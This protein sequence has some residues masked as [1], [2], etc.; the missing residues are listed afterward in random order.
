MTPK[1]NEIPIVGIGVTAGSLNELE[2]FL[3][4]TPKKTGIVFA[5]VQYLPV[6]VKSNISDFIKQISTVPIKLIKDG[7]AY[8]ANKL[9][10][11]PDGFFLNINNGKFYLVQVEDDEKND[12]INRFFVSL[13]DYKKAKTTAIL[14]SSAGEDGIS[15]TK[16]MAEHGGLFFS[17]AL[18]EPGKKLNFE[19]IF[20]KNG[21]TD[22]KI[23]CKDILEEI[24]KTNLERGF[25][26][27]NQNGDK[28]KLELYLN[29]IFIHLL[30][31]TGHDFSK[32]KRGTIK[33]RIERRLVAL[34]IDKLS[35]YVELLVLDKNEALNLKKEL[36]ISVT[37]FFRDPQ[38]FEDL[39]DKIIPEMIAS[40]K[41]GLIRIWIPACATGEE[42]YT[43]TMIMQ[44]YIDENDLELQ[45][46]VF[47]SDID[48]AAIEK[49]REGIYSQEIAD[50]IPGKYLDKYFTRKNNRYRVDKQIREK[51]IFAEQNVLQDPPYS[52]MDLI[53]C[54]NLLIY[55][56]NELQEQALATFHYALKSK[57]YLLLGNSESLGKSTSL[58]ADVN[59]KMKLFQKVDNVINSTRYW[60]FTSSKIYDKS[61]NMKQNFS[62]Q[63][64]LPDLA[65]EVV[66][67]RF[68]PPVIIINH[69]LDI[70]YLHGRTSVYLEL[71][72]GVASLNIL[73]SVL[74][75]LKAPLGTTI[76]RARNTGEEIIKR[77]VKIDTERISSIIDI[78][79]SPVKY[80][81]KDTDMLMVTF[82]ESSIVSDQA[83]V[84]PTESEQIA[85][86]EKELKETQDYLQST[87]EELETTNEELKAAN[88]EE[89]STNEELQSANEELE[90]S[91]E[92]LQAVNEELISANQELQNK[93]DELSKAN[94]DIS[95][96]FSSTQIATVFL[97]KELR[98]T[99]FTNSIVNI[100]D[101]MPTD[102]G[103]PIDQFTNKLEYD[104]F[105]EDIWEVIHSLK[106][107][108]MEV[109]TSDNSYFWM[110]VNP[111]RTVEGA[112]EGVCVTFT[113][114]SEKKK[115]EEELVRYKNHLEDLVEER[116]SELTESMRELDSEKLK[117]Q[118][119]LD[120]AAV[121]FISLDLHGNLTLANIHASEVLGY[122]QQ[123]LVGMNWFEHFLPDEVKTEIHDIFDEM[124]NSSSQ[125]T[126]PH[127]NE[128]IIKDG[129][130]RT[131]AWNNVLIKDEAGDI[132]GFLSSGEDIT[133]RKEA[134]ESLQESE[135][136]LRL[137]QDAG[138][139]GM[140]VLDFG[141]KS[142]SASEIFFKIHGLDVTNSV[143]LEDFIKVL[144]ESEIENVSKA[145]ND[146]FKK[147]EPYEIEHQVTDQKTREKKWVRASGELVCDEAGNRLKLIGTSQDITKRKEAE[148][149]LIRSREMYK[150]LFNNTGA[151]TC[152][153]GND[154]ILTK[155]NQMFVE[156]SGFSA[157]DIV[158][159]KIWSDF[160]ADED[161]ERIRGYHQR[162]SL[163]DPDVPNEYEFRF[164]DSK[165]D[166][167][168]I[169][170]KISV[171][172]ETGIRIASLLNI[173]ARVKAEKAIMASE[174][175][176]KSIFEYS[177][178]GIVIGS[179]DGDL[180]D[181]NDEFIQML[182]YSKEELLKKNYSEFTHPEDLESEVKFFDELI[183]GK[184]ENYRIEKR[185]INSSNEIVWVDFSIA[186][187]RNEKGEI[188]FLIGMVKDMT[189]R[190]MFQQELI[191]QN[192]FIQ[193]ILDNLP[194]G[195]ATNS[196]N[197]GAAGYMNA[198]FEEIYG[199]A[200]TEIPSIN[201]FFEKVYPDEEYKKQIKERVM[202]DIQSGDPSRMHWEDIQITRSDGAQRTINAINIPL[203]DQNMMVSTV[204]DVTDLKETQE[205][206]INAKEEAE[207]ANNL[208]SAFLANTSHE[209]RTPL[210]G[211]IGFTD[212]LEEEM[213]PTPK[214][215][216]YL[217]V[218]KNS[219]QQLLAIIGDI[220]DI[221]KIDT[222]QMS[223]QEEIVNL[224]DLMK[225]VYNFHI[226]SNLYK[227]KKDVELQLKR[228]NQNAIVNADLARLRQILDNLVTNALK[229]TS[230][231]YVKFGYSIEKSGIEI[232]VND[233]GLGIPEG[234]EENIFG[235]F[236]KLGSKAGTG[237]G[238]SI[239]KGLVELM[240]GEISLTSK[241]EK[242]TNFKINLPFAIQE[243][244]LVDE[245]T[246][247]KEEENELNLSGK[248]ILVAEDDFSSYFLIEQ[249]LN[250]TKARIVHA[251][252]GQEV[253]DLMEKEKAELILMDINMPVMDGLEATRLVREADNK[254]PIVAQTAYAMENEK[255]KCF[256]AGCDDYI[257]KPLTKSILLEKL[258]KL[259]L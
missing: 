8:K 183:K 103:R 185:Y 110:R 14:F 209:I 157:T 34:K 42:A 244:S 69:N 45:L 187:R 79:V 73:N 150:D 213:D 15:G 5:L 36:L 99:R 155:C 131:V 230:K 112:V 200:S 143:S 1:K 83:D 120:I 204:V 259:M 164:I 254:I 153:F 27:E 251:Q 9:Y 100:I 46:Q 177:N 119:Y 23:A 191:V 12:P 166:K 184:R 81:G 28:D 234:Q 233:T 44:N 22:H 173:S 129:S 180:L 145:F 102:L 190:V 118:Q 89:Q 255:L 39:S 172:K 152:T 58:F 146:T 203:E 101:L 88:E 109:K 106:I 48:V 87:I 126:I 107:K 198:K 54:R 221:S 169:F 181:A 215:E 57:G 133:E 25:D 113:E 50:S 175:K 18:K 4:N 225:E 231:G 206:L 139:I 82:K 249:F 78:I 105:V 158:G 127:E 30:K 202:N 168:H 171:N 208:K 40:N 257:S 63:I 136:N 121:I 147:G 167:K 192:D 104:T 53:S 256:E 32:Y 178:T 111:Y 138:N 238:L 13:A 193:K 207:K 199:W 71:S 115:Q 130:R 174:E 65:K 240:K 247:S 33:R 137:A 97:D 140:W 17:K 59:R 67:D 26:I 80:E 229:Y 66:L 189:D 35:E 141:S 132:I 56:N 239:V 162:R 86:L 201:D 179:I 38:I 219:G 7:M 210:N 248:T 19:E 43:L 47:S 252:T 250:E 55:L 21:N 165:G 149:S 94:N 93:I 74:D 253:L 135:S 84:T 220:I 41:G 144:P 90:T 108:E 96:L 116:T 176:F 24:I 188:D 10:I 128:I 160:V 20:V 62:Q 242:G 235:R 49:A 196:I 117:A 154:G 258:K 245:E 159:K 72:S 64:H 163:G 217:N 37:S 224:D 3:V 70:L 16:Y 125:M 182:G 170:L 61:N 2:E 241:E 122:S 227:E 216:L 124:I 186:P 195:V 11:C 205:R 51:I 214:S 211:I 92:E 223:L 218:V 123:E 98:I 75:V 91:K 68:T 77:N 194:I 142:I 114:I 226:H 222:N 161:L 228:S 151:A 212:L 148:E 197:D 95:N 31:H 6:G 232:F 237:L 243:L 29:K 156:L 85:E 236:V 60:S 76:R 134:L 246:S 52:N